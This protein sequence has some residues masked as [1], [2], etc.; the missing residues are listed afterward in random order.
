MSEHV[1]RAFAFMA[2]GDMAGREREE[3]EVGTVVR[4]P[5]LPLRQDSNYLLVDRTDLSAA[6]LAA[7]VRRLRL[8]VLVVRDEATSER[9]AG[10][11]DAIGW[12]SHAHV[13]MVQR[14]PPERPVDAALATEVDEATLRS[15]RR[16]S[17]LAAPW[18]RAELAEQILRAKQLI[19]ERMR[20]RFFAVLV[21]GVP[22]AAADLYLDGSEAQIED[23]FTLEEHR[24]RGCASALVSRAAEEA[25]A[26]GATF[27][28]LVARADDWPR[29]LYERL[30]FETVGGYYKFFL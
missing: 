3:T 10:A 4:S 7:D 2:R 21:D 11:F 26:A 27:V 30:G 24:N 29:L 28:F 22:V 1:D 16:A 5:E 19:G 14:R 20:T 23:V 9:L 13:V 25:R 12:Q 15:F 6:R 8:R 18:G 17:V